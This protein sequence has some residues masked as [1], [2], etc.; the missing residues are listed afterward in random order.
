MPGPPPYRPSSVVSEILF[1]CGYPI[2]GDVHT[3]VYLV[4]GSQ[5]EYHLELTYSILSALHHAGKQDDLTIALFTDEANRRTDLPVKN[6]VFSPAEFALWTRGNLYQHEAKVHIL[7]KALDM[8]KGKIALIDTDTYF[9]KDPRVLFDRIAP[10][11]SVM[12]TYEGTLGN[13]PILSPLLERVASGSSTYPISAA[14]RLFNSGVIGVDY[15]DRAIID[16]ILPALSHY[17][18]RYPAFNIEQFAVSIVLDRRTSLTVAADLIRHYWG[19]ER[20]FIHLRIAQLFPDFTPKLFGRHLR[21]LP[22]VGGWGRKRIIDQVRARLKA[23]L[24]QEG[25]NYRFAYLAYLSA[26][27]NIHRSPPEA[28]VWAQVAAA[29]LRQ[30]EFGITEVQEDFTRMLRPETWPWASDSTRAAWATVRGELNQARERGQSKTSVGLEAV[31]R[32][33]APAPGS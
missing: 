6:F 1:R 24:R 30:H 26:L 11:S 18:M 5:R 21:K 12:H 9:L 4:Y 16:D 3:L 22:P 20:G 17:Y 25:S 19:D 13:D 10:G 14:T 23:T 7:M 29:M 2:G 31:A 27:A 28:N 33:S 32:A 15:A 8:F